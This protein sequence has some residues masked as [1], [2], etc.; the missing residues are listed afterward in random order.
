MARMP[1]Q[2]V[3][4]FT[5]GPTT[6]GTATAK[7][8]EQGAPS[9]PPGLHPPDFTNW[10]LPLPEAPLTGRLPA[11]SGG[12]PAI[13][14]QTVGPRAPGPQAQGQWALVP[15]MQ[16]PSAPQGMPLVR[17]P[18]LHHPATPYQQVVQPPSQPATL[19]QQAVQPP[20]RPAGRRGAAQPPSNRA[21]PAAGQ[22]I[23]NHRR[24]QAR[25]RGIRGRSVSRPGHG[26]GMA[27]NVPQTTTPG[28]TQPQPGHRARPRCSDLAVLASKYHSGG[29]RKD[30]EHVLRVYYKH[31]IQ[32]P[33]REPEWI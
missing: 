12:L 21:T 6:P 19:Y 22:T 8:Q 20:R 2:G 17:Q 4:A 30:L 13:G 33:F 15:P 3:A 25:G 9:P 11:P 1:R 7:V 23:P 10:S 27:T 32:A 31:S 16:A 26:Q 14:R 5:G 29:W 24:Q 18:R 28:A